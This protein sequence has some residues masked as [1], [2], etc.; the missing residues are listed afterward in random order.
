[1]LKVGTKVIVTYEGKEYDGRITSVDNDLRP[2]GVKFYAGESLTFW[3]LPNFTCPSATFRIKEKPIDKCDT[4]EYKRAVEK[5][6]KQQDEWLAKHTAKPVVEVKRRARVGEFVKIVCDSYGEYRKDAIHEV[7]HMHDED[8]CFGGKKKDS[9]RDNYLW[10]S[11]YVVLENYVPKEEKKI[12]P[13]F[14]VGDIVRGT[15]ADRYAMTNSDMTKGKVVGVRGD[16][17]IDIVILETKGEK[18]ICK[19]SVFTVDT[20]YFELAPKIEPKIGMY[21]EITK[22]ADDYLVGKIVKITK[23]EASGTIEFD[24]KTIGA[25]PCRHRSTLGYY[26]LL[27]D[28][29]PM[30]KW[31]D[32]EIQEAKNIIAEI[33]SHWTLW[34]EKTVGGDKCSY[35]IGDRSATSKPCPTDEYSKYIGMMVAAC[36]LT[37]RELPKWIKKASK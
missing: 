2:Y 33:C 9:D 8:P 19:D 24:G 32:A 27:P 1:M 31:T 26:E 36:K 7:T 6:R 16:K 30:R 17:Y 22:S 12:E 11:E 37:G 29:K 25:M 20:Q 34:F 13:K 21:A 3:F 28:Y 5:K 18:P 14:K 35:V 4:C 10:D 15:S 23:V